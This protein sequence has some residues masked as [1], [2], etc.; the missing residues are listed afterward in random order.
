[1]ET[2]EIATLT[3]ERTPPKRRASDEPESAYVEK[4]I[5]QL[6]KDKER[7]AKQHHEAFMT[8]AK[9]NTTK[10]QHHFFSHF[11]SRA[12][13]VQVNLVAVSDHV[14]PRF[15]VGF[16]F[17]VSTLFCFG[18]MSQPFVVGTP[19][20]MVWTPAVEGP[21]MKSSMLF[22]QNLYSRNADRANSCSHDLDV[23]YGFTYH[24]DTWIWRLDLQ[25]WNRTS[26]LSLQVRDI[27]SLSIK[28]QYPGLH[29]NKL[30]APQPLSPMAQ[31]HLMTDRN[32]RRRLNISS[33]PEDEHARSAVSLRFACEQNHKGITKWINNHWIPSNMPADSRLVTI[34]CKAGSM[35]VRLVF[36]T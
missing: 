28:W 34:H 20:S 3:I 2:E 19:C 7:L 31:D 22:F 30:T 13:L 23:P 32:T 10:S 4:S 9:Q 5:E 6:T 33:S 27:C 1:M 21:R 12:I 18:L 26:V 15:F 8:S 16:L 17:F 25:R 14:F 35:S 24:E 29:S 36:E 11:V